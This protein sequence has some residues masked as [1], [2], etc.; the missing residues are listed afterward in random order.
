MSAAFHNTTHSSGAELALYE[1]TA[2]NQ[3][4]AVL[5][6]FRSRMREALT[7]SQVWGLI[8]TR[9]PLTSIRRAIT[10]L[11]NAGFLV[12]TER[13]DRGP[14]GKPEHLWRYIPP[15]QQLDMFGGRQA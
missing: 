5:A 12:K 3:D 15:E 8:D 1:S 13:Q 9:A 7:P 2:K 6:I 10:N 14:Y 4:V 11:T